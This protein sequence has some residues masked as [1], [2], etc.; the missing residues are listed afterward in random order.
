MLDLVWLRRAVL[1]LLG[2]VGCVVVFPYSVSA[3]ATASV[4]LTWNPSISTNVVSYN[5]Y[6]GT[7]SGVYGSSIS[8]AGAAST[9]A[10]VT[11]LVQG[12]TY[13]FAATAV[14]ALGNQSP[15]SN[16]TSYSVPTAPTP[17]A[18]PTLNVINNVAINENAG[19]QTVN[20][21][22]IS[23]GAANESQ[24]LTVTAS[25]SNPGLIPNPTVNYTSPNATG[26]LSFAPAANR[27]GAATVTVTVNDNGA[28]NNIVT[29]SFTVTVNPVNQPPTLNPLSNVAV[30]E[31]A[32]S[33]TVNLSGI[34]SGAANE[35]QTLTVTASS[36]NPGLIPNPTV[37]YASPNA[38]GTLSFAPAANGFGTATVTVTVNDNGASN[39]IVTHSFTV[40]VNPVNQPPTLNPLS[41]VAV[42][43][44]AGS[45]TVNLSGI[46]SGA[47][48]ESQTL[49][50][51]ASSSNPGLI[52]NPTVNYT[53]PNATG[54]LSFTPA[55]N[56]FG[57]ATV[58]VTVNDN[59]ASN[60]IVTHS[61]TVTVNPVNQPPTLNPLS[62]VAVNENAGSQ[63]VNLS[64]ISS[65]AANESQT[66]TV[67]ASSSNP[68]LIPNPTVNYTS[69]NATGTLSFTPAANGFG[70]A[71]VTVTVNDNGASNNIVTHSFT[72]T[73][74]PVNQPPTLDPLSDM[75]ISEDDGLQTI[76]LTGIT[77]GATN[78]PQTLTVT[79]ASSNPGLIPNPTV[80]Y[81]SPNATGTLSFAPTTNSYGTAIVT[82]T[83]SDGDNTVAQSF[84]VT[85][86]YVSQQIAGP[87]PTIKS[88]PQTQTAEVGGVA[89]MN[90]R[91]KSDSS[92][93][94]AWFFN[95]NPINGS[96]TNR[97][98]LTGVQPAN[99]GTYT[100]VA[101]NA[102]GSVTSA[103]AALNVIAPVPRRLVPNVTLRS[104]RGSSVGID[105]SDA[106]GSAANW[107]TIAT[108]TMSSSTES[109]FDIS[110]PLPPQRF[111]RVW[112][113]GTSGSAPTLAVTPV[114]AITLAGN[115][116][117]NLRLD[118]INTFG[119]TNAWV[120]LATV[121]LTN[122][123]QL[124]FD[125]SAHSKAGR[126]YRI[127][128][129]P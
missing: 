30:N 9:N 102:N 45:Q 39:N 18:P 34:S 66:L 104:E 60:N 120:T 38:T 46:S 2:V 114:Q 72:V 12:T 23:S 110:D 56:R 58:T 88:Q 52:P 17:N 75:E 96:N 50:V 11:G 103:P 95:G 44:N 116:G 13:Y 112:N 100:L 80:N 63:T 6:Y 90:S 129:A 4:K 14:D 36:S 32:G 55:A 92:V 22:G 124:F 117:S 35:S 77:S 68:G 119:P 126:L 26:T 53:S 82:V 70:T 78:E 67:T 106:A 33:Q 40:T 69:P 65:G 21:S 118:Y 57:T 79:A 99:I 5:V 122:T 62:N 74:N 105:Y 15:Y 20:L 73:V 49:T 48:N 91:V 3:A 41:N 1:L 98:Y 107:T 54:T 111:Y 24:T 7:A 61:F 28:S 115:I 29:R 121:T 76:N 85:V 125:T 93:T 8:V 101:G 81:T 89:I 27:S 87:V 47:A 10:T 83:V 59:G 16:E 127:V 84:T 71:T 108:M 19:L 128:P 97:L 43:E 42:N 37:N 94:Y 64:G 51:T 113:S 86:D 25:S 31:N 109:Y 123:S